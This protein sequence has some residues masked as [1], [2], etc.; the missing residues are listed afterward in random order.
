MLY[1]FTNISG[2]LNASVRSMDEVEVKVED[3]LI[4]SLSLH[5]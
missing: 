5:L 2:E 3:D 1:I 4:I